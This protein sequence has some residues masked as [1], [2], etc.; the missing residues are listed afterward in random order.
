MRMSKLTGISAILMVTA[1]CAG[2]AVTPGTPRAVAKAAAEAY[3]AA[4]HK[5]QMKA[6]LA[7][8][9][10]QGGNLPLM[11]GYNKTTQELLFATVYDTE[12]GFG[13]AC[14][15]M[16]H[17]VDQVFRPEWMVVKCDQI[18]YDNKTRKVVLSVIGGGRIPDQGMSRAEL[19]RSAGMFMQEA[20]GYLVR[21]KAAAQSPAQSPVITGA[22]QNASPVSDTVNFT[23]L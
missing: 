18:E 13:R 16:L 21:L 1:G 12:A 11:M 14:A 4:G 10:T 3:S 22:P 17:G 20:E 23:K 5:C 7:Y 8:C 15:D 6:D 9:D 2:S 19:N